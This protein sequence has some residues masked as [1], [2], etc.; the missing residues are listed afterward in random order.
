MN[1]KLELLF[2]RSMTAI[3]FISQW[4]NVTSPVH[5]KEPKLK[6]QLLL[7]ITDQ[8]DW[9]LLLYVKIPMQ[10][11]N[12]DSDNENDTD[13]HGVKRVRILSYSGPNAGKYSP[14]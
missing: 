13:S 9:V 1:K 12:T 11:W 4:A 8:N 10:L 2:L 14:E 3:N 7:I 6:K 5:I